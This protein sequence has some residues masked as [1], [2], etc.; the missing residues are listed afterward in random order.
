MLPREDKETTNYIFQA[1]GDNFSGRIGTDHTGEFLYFYSQENYYA[2]I[3]YNYDS[4]TILAELMKSRKGG[5][6]LR[7]YRKIF[8]NI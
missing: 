4:N 5:E 2:F 7:A 6:S 3:I 1:M 8:L